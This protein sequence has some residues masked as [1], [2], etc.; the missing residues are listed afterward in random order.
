MRSL[1]SYAS[2]TVFGSQAVHCPG[3]RFFWAYFRSDGRNVRLVVN[4]AIKLPWSLRRLW[5]ISGLLIHKHSTRYYT[6]LAKNAFLTNPAHSDF[7]AGN[8]AIHR[9]ERVRCCGCTRR[10]DNTFRMDRDSLR[11][12]GDSQSWAFWTWLINSCTL[13]NTR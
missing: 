13:T 4:Y 7:H 10:R 5:N 8:T 2:P 12:L 9:H 6:I 11:Q 1:V 3:P